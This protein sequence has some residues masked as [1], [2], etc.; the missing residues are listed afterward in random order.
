MLDR[1][2]FVEFQE[3]DELEKLELTNLSSMRVSNRVIH[4]SEM[5]RRARVTGGGPGRQMHPLLFGVF[6]LRAL[7]C[8]G[9]LGFEGLGFDQMV[10]VPRL[11]RNA[12]LLQ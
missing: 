6:G 11:T 2:P 5:L 1:E 3:E 4:P 9:C 8:L 7:G 12:F 10:K